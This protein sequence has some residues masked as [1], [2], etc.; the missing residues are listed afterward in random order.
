M[1]P[2]YQYPTTT[3]TNT[4]NPP[5]PNS[6]DSR[7]CTPNTTQTRSPT[8]KPK[9]PSKSTISKQKRLTFTCPSCGIQSAGQAAGVTHCLET[10]YS[11]A[12]VNVSGTLRFKDDACPFLTGGGAQK[13][14]GRRFEGPNWK[15]N[16]AHHLSTHV[17]RE[18]QFACA[19][20]PKRYMNQKSLR[21]HVKEHEGGVFPCDRCLE[22]FPTTGLRD[23]HVAE[24]RR[25]GDVKPIRKMRDETCKK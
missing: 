1:M 13:S 8:T 24:H 17:V 3:T 15:H 25:N 23:R 16:M 22:T 10:C 20:C 12:S 7:R 6:S 19:V 9:P 14:C 4:M 2:L 5:S 21:N 11:H 18:R